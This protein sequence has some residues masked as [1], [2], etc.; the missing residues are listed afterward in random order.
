MRPDETARV[1]P[2]EINQ[3]LDPNLTEDKTKWSL[4]LYTS[5]RHWTIGLD[6]LF[7]G[8]GIELA[9]LCFVLDLHW[10]EP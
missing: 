1:N 10:G 4:R 8:H 6:V 9:T 7:L 5:W 2:V 3:P